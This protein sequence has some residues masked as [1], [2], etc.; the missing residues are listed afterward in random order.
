[1]RIADRIPRQV[2]ILKERSL[3][4]LK[5]GCGSQRAGGK[6]ANHKARKGLEP[7]GLAKQIVGGEVKV[8][9]E[10]LGGWNT[11]FREWETQ[12]RLVLER[13]CAGRDHDG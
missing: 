8:E 7:A 6:V 11:T 2:E 5:G 3:Q 10:L 9:I 4:C 13:G 12:G 1:M